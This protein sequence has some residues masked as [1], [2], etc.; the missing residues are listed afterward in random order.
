MSR[1][2]GFTFIEL[3]V[4]LTISAV[5][6]A[7]FVQYM[8]S[9][10]LYSGRE[11]NT[12]KETYAINQVIVKVT[13]DYRNE[14]E[15]DSLDLTVFKTDID[16]LNFD[17]NGVTCSAMFLNFR[18]VDGDGTLLESNGIIEPVEPASGSTK[19]LLVT[20]SKINRSMRVLLTA[21]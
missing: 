18:D 8:G 20:A 10:F 17:E 9:A 6:A 2:E 14:L 1:M 12:L 3:I 21:E 7:F 13:A 19:F 15:N 16:N 11:V 4:A 5:L